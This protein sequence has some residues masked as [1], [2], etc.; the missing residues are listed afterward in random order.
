V[1][2]NQNAAPRHFL[3]KDLAGS[4]KRL[5]DAEIDTLLAAVAAEAG[6][7]DQLP[8]QRIDLSDRPI[9]AEEHHLTKGK[10][11]AVRA[12]FGKSAVNKPI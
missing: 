3:P 12:A 10:L 4:L 9:P 2:Q 7:R 8:K 1:L 6:R 11:N 5:E